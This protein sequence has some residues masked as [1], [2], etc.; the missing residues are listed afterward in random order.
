MKAITAKRETLDDLKQRGLRLLARDLLS[1]GFVELL[2][3][4]SGLAASQAYV[5]QRG[6]VVHVSGSVALVDRYVREINT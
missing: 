2:T 6:R 1:R 5:T 4:E 3:L